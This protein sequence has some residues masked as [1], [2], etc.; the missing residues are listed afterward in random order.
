[1]ASS[2]LLRRDWI[3]AAVAAGVVGAITFDA[4][5]LLVPWPGVPYVGVAE[6]YPYI[7]SALVGNIALGAA[8]GFPLGVLV[9][10]TVAVGWSYAYLATAQTLPQLLRRPAISG[11]VFGAVV[12]FVMQAILL[13]IGKNAPIT[14]PSFDQQ[15]IAHTLFFGL[16]LALVASRIARP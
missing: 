14:I 8:W 12:W 11:I 9:H 7:A 15:I 13:P 2:T 1:M 4:F 5:L 16:P 6:L 10:L 3:G